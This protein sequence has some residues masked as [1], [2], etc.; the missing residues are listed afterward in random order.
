MAQIVKCNSVK[1]VSLSDGVF[2]ALVACTFGL[3]NSSYAQSSSQPITG[4]CAGIINTSNIYSALIENNDKSIDK[5]H[6]VVDVAKRLGIPD[7]F[8]YKKDRRLPYYLD[9][10]RARL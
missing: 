2:C 9:S 1:N 7:I 4:S 6:L 3:G 5:G 10:H 8:L